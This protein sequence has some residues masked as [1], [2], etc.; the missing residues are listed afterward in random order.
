MRL[1][2]YSDKTQL[3]EPVYSLLRLT[4]F[5]H[6]RVSPPFSRRTTEILVSYDVCKS[7]KYSLLMSIRFNKDVSWYLAL[8]PFASFLVVLVQ[9]HRK[10][11]TKR[12]NPTTLAFDNLDTNLPP[13]S[14]AKF[15]GGLTIFAFLVGRVVACIMLFLTASCLEFPRYDPGLLTKGFDLWIP[16]YYVRTVIQNRNIMIE[17]INVALLHTSLSC[18]SLPNNIPRYLSFALF[19]ASICR[20]LGGL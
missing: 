11:S 6:E 1:S 7:P 4:L 13:E 16:I 3:E 8:L 19:R 15:H 12:A 18:C 9:C 5:L 14:L 2:R 10:F 20:P 17:F